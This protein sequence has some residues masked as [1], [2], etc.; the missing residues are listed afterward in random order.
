MAAP[1][2]SLAF[3]GVWDSLEVG[4]VRLETRRFVTPYTVVRGSQRESI[5][6]VYRYEEDV[7]EPRDPGAMNLAAMIGAQVALNYG[8]FCDEIVF[9]GPF[10][11]IDRRFL[12]DM[13]ENTAREIYVLKLLEWNPFLVDGARGLEARSL[14]RYCRAR[15][16]FEPDMPARETS[17]D[18]IVRSDAHAV[19]SSG[20]KDSLLS[21]GLLDEIGVETHPLFVNESGRHWY[22]ALHA[23]RHFQD[24]VPNTARVWTNADRVFCWALRQ[25]PFVRRNFHRMRSDEYPIRLWTVAVFLFG[26]L[27]LLRSRG[28][29]RL[30]IGNEHDTTSRTT[31]QGITHYSGLYDQSRFFDERLTRYFE[32]KG[33]NVVQFSLLRSLSELLIEKLLSERYPDLLVHQISCHATHI[34]GGRVR[35]CGHCEKCRRVVGMLTAIGRDP[36][37]CG[38]DEAQIASCLKELAVVGAQQEASGVE[39]LLFMLERR[40]AF[41]RL[42]T[43]VEGA[44]ERPEVLKLRV[45]PERSPV[46]CVP[47]DLRDPVFDILKEH[48][49]G[50]VR[51]VEGRWIDDAWNPHLD[52]ASLAE[53]NVV[54]HPFRREV[55]ASHGAEYKDFSYRYFDDPE[56]VT[57]FGGYRADGS[58][59]EGRRDFCAEARRI[60]SIPGVRTVLD[61]GCAKGYLVRALRERGVDARGIDVS[62]YAVER[63][64]RETRPF[65]RVLDARDIPSTERYDLVHACGILAYLELSE[66]RAVLHRLHAV[67]CLGAMFDE[68]TLERLLSLYDRGDPRAIDPLRK[69][70]LPEMAW[71]G[72]FREAGF[73]QSDDY[74]RKVFIPTGGRTEAGD[75]RVNGQTVT[76]RGLLIPMDWDEH[77]NPRSV[78]LCTA[79]ERDI[80]IEEG[81]LW[82]Q[83]LEHLAREV[84]VR[85]TVRPGP[86]GFGTI[87]IHRFERIDWDGDL[88]RLFPEDTGPEL[89]E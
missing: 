20:G 11:P 4:P 64:D 1:H 36:S 74:H 48:V 49:R 68:L 41:D 15:L 53:V 73:T 85:G 6:L 67:V 63:A 37:E 77:D 29:E 54:E 16:V 12:A 79:D 51:W 31:H 17:P 57:G 71:E 65:L 39:Q 46:E 38:Y 24:D 27:P 44:R 35:P 47:P 10:D 13:A 45:H 42:G 22:T 59:A 32:T 40:G 84:W 23:Y 56:T 76:L 34:H 66:I 70:E 28:I 2:D 86:L 87:D 78:A 81:P 61:V 62:E 19:L 75:H 30:V 9:R 43:Q 82:D 8:L 55:Q 88:A 50:A 21:F 18:W 60:A 58:K 25:L 5:D 3:L 52:L 83:L 72:L 80:F 26:A 7:F 69:Q 33:W 89:Y 14:P